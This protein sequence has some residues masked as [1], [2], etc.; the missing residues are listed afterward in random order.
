MGKASTGGINDEP[1]SQLG[2]A[3]EKSNVFKEGKGLTKL[4]RHQG[5]LRRGG[6]G[7]AVKTNTKCAITELMLRLSF[8]QEK[9]TVTHKCRVLR[10]EFREISFSPLSKQVCFKKNSPFLF[11]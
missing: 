11:I 8:L 10:M 9:G 3:A 5:Q 4:T 2:G 1:G 7:M 6:K